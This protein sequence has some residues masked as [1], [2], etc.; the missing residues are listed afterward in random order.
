VRIVLFHPVRLPALHYGGVERVVLWLA[1][2]LQARGHDVFVAA[3]EGSRLPKGI[4]AIEMS[5]ERRSAFDLLPL[6]PDRVDCVHFMAPPEEGVEEQLPCPS[7][8]TV[9]GNGKP[10]E[11]FPRAS[12][13]LSR[14]HAQRHGRKTFVYNGLD[15]SE[16]RALAWED[17]ADYA[18]FLS[19]TSWRVKNVRG[20]ARIAARAG[21]PLQI[22]GG[23]RPLSVRLQCAFRPSWKWWGSV[24]GDEKAKLLGSARA[25]VFP[26]LWDEPFGLVIA[27]ALWSGCPV[28]ARAQGSVPELVNA[29]VGALFQSDEEAVELLR[30]FWAERHSAK[31]R[32]LSERARAWASESFHYLKMAEN[33][34]KLYSARS[35]GEWPE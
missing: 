31:A 12:V 17:R 8:T 34:E 21:V 6:L 35:R 28:F 7:L 27:E 4:H 10:A 20:A 30:E 22:A 9:H 14:D 13:F 26:I 11:Q 32:N 5:T 19:K 18:A 15:P 29:E 3:L 24:G 16:F 1:R 33:Y 2:G 23:S 25:F